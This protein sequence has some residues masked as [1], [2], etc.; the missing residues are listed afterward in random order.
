MVKQLEVNHL[1]VNFDDRTVINDVSL[2]LDAGAIGCILGLSGC[3]KTT[4]LRVIAGFQKPSKGKVFL[5]GKQI[6]SANQTLPPEQRNIGM[7]FQDFALFPNLTVAQNIGFGLR[8]WAI[9]A[10]KQRVQELLKLIELTHLSE[11]YSHQLSGGEQ[12]R[13]ALARAIA[14]KPGILLM[15]EP[16]SSMDVE[17]R[18]QLAREIRAILKKEK[19]TAILVTHDQ[20]EAFVMADEI[21][22]MNGG[23]IQ[24]CDTGYK[25]YHQPK[26]QFV[27]GFIGQGVLLTGEVTTERKI[28]TDLGMLANECPDEFDAGELIRL[29]IRPNE[30]IYDEHAKIQAE[31]VDKAFRGAEFLYTLKIPTGV[32]L[33]FLTA[34]HF[35]INDSIGVRLEVDRLI[36]FKH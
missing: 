14:P 22:V 9:K 15:D 23:V 21:C 33:L 35:H 6:S 31:I 27:A 16:F 7:V 13:V 19:I 28:K 8:H 34:E 2:T 29:L 17:L 30:V 26:N 25:L 4:L 12:Q 36:V 11:A 24:Q 32:K 20:H 5:K 1:S 3:G 10:K 18:D